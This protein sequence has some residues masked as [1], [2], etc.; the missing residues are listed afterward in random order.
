MRKIYTILLGGALVAL[1]SVSA[2]ADDVK[3]VPYS[4]PIYL[5]YNTLADGWENIDGNEDGKAWDGHS[6]T[7]SQF[8][9]GTSYAARYYNTS[10]AV[11]MGEDWMVSPPIHLEAGQEYKVLYIWRVESS[12]RPR[13]MEIHATTSKQLSKLK[14]S[15]PVKSYV[16]YNNNVFTRDGFTFT[17]EETGDYYFSFTAAVPAENY[18]MWVANLEVYKNEFTPSPVTNFTAVRD[19]QRTISATLNWT[20]PTTSTFGDPFTEEQ[21]VEAVNIY[22]DGSQ[23][24]VAVLSGDDDLT[25]FVDTEANGLTVGEHSYDVEVVVA[26]VKSGKVNAKTK[27]VGPVQPAAVPYVW[28]I[29]SADEFEDWTVIKGAES[30]STSNWNYYSS[31]ARFYEQKE[32]KEYDF[33]ASPPFAIDKPGYYEVTIKAGPSTT[34]YDCT[35]MLVYGKERTE[36]GLGNVIC[37][38][39]PFRTANN[40]DYSYVVRI[41]DPDT[42]YFAAVAATESPEYSYG[43]TIYVC[44]IGVKETEKTPAAVTKLKA[45]PD[46]DEALEVTLSWTCP[47]KS[48]NGEDLQPEEYSIEVYKGETL[49]TTLPGGTT[50]YV[51]SNIE[52]PGVYTYS[53]KTVAPQGAS[54]GEVTVTSPWVGDH[55]VSLPYATSFSSSD[56]TVNVWDAVDAN[57][58][59]KTWHMYSSSM[60]CSQG[61]NP[62]KE[63]GTREYEDYLLSPYFDMT[64]GYYEFKFKVVGGSTTN[65]YTH[66]VGI[67]KA[68]NFDASNVELLFPETFVS[69]TT[70]T[71][72]AP[73]V[74]YRVK[75]E[76]AGKY[77]IVFAAIEDLKELTGYSDDDYYYYGMSN[78]SV[79]SLP[80]LPGIVSDLAVT[81]AE[82]EVCEALVSWTNPTETNIEGESIED[83]PLVKAVIIR[84]GEEIGEVTENLVPGQISTFTDNEESGLTP[85]KHVYSVEVY[86]EAGKSAEAAPSIESEWI[87]GA[88]EAPVYFEGND[89]GDWSFVDVHGNQTSTYDG[90]SVNST[91]MRVDETNAGNL[92]DDWAISPLINFKKHNIYTLTFKYYLGRIYAENTGYTIDLYIGSGSDVSGYTK[93]GELVFQDEDG[94]SS[95]PETYEIKIKAM[96]SDSPAQIDAEE[97]P[98]DVLVPV[99]SQSIALRA[100]T[101][102][103]GYVKSL[104]IS[105][106]VVVGVDNIETEISGEARYYN[107]Q[108]IQVAKPVS[109]NIYIKVEGNKSTKV[110]VK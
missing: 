40:V 46:V 81:P 88:L 53:V 72:S 13:S 84:D 6:Q 56:Q 31:N 35:L 74:A 93:F 80:V 77:Q 15:E 52:N 48:S 30:V 76:E 2:K 8:N 87:G 79:Q 95:Y 75:I 16:D 70:S 83:Y 21:T 97:D 73:E 10:T 58:D 54:V 45:T 62:G 29:T 101:K 24:P 89:F 82:N 61:V 55:T 94:T 7:L 1:G 98:Y 19:P 42:Y 66:H 67:V 11:A 22:R 78:F 92:Y 64:P 9:L 32:L 4:S 108:G 27:Y 33:L 18:W 37:E 34:N 104:N 50:S 102:G 65:S 68:K 44:S 17:P 43:P 91:S 110:I 59:G 38:K 49:V 41:D 14:A 100:H 103:G 71:Y 12:S 3:S 90:W 105:E 106:G 86:N 25:Q 99:G 20:L 5:D 39:I 69:T 85:G 60:R 36:E 57:E 47:D 109:G 28:D 51:D 96:K 107:L 26:G 63:E 23:E